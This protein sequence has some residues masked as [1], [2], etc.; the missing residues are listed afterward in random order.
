MFILATATGG[1]L[2][3]STGRFDADATEFR[4]SPTTAPSEM[5]HI[6]VVVDP[7]ADVY[8]DGQLAVTTPSAASIPLSPGRHYLKFQNPYFHEQTREVLVYAGAT[9][10]IIVSLK[11]RHADDYI[12]G[13]R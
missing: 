11:P 1:A 5:G 12:E 8:I 4:S 3:A 9:E 10:E 7:W 13:G 2:Q 6:K